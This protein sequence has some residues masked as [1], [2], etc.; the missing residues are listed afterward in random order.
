[1]RCRP[2]CHGA[3]ADPEASTERRCRRV[4][5]LAIQRD[6]V[7]VRA[8]QLLRTP[9][10]KPVGGS[11]SLSGWRSTSR[12]TGAHPKTSPVDVD[13]VGST[14]FAAE[15]GWAG[16]SAAA[17][18]AAAAAAG[19]CPGVIVPS[20]RSSGTRRTD[21]VST[22]S[23]L[24]V[25]EASSSWNVQG[26]RPSG[27]SGSTRTGQHAP[28]PHS[29]VPA[30]VVASLRPAKCATWVSRSRRPAMAV[31]ARTGTAR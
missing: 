7:S 29:T 22:R 4:V 14:T 18:A 30:K 1:M 12:G 10:T 9:A 28:V 6:P 17:A 21:R 2:G 11:C 19:R 25:D 8:R 16:Q 24:A 23:R 20:P 27:P 26:S 3:T 13:S 5:V 31:V 15:A